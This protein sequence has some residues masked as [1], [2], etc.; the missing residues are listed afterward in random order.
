MLA[1]FVFHNKTRH[2][3]MNLFTFSKYFKH[4]D[5]YTYEKGE[6]IGIR[7]GSEGITFAIAGYKH[8]ID[9]LN[10]VQKIETIEAVIG[11]EIDERAY[12]GWQGITI[13]MCN[14]L[15]RAVTGIDIAFTWS[16]RHMY[17]KLLK[18]DRQS[19]YEIFYHWRRNN[20]L[21]RRG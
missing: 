16:P 14:E 10:E 11:A 20:G 6:W 12:F 8:G 5:I 2:K 7:M 18:Y 4:V 1:L 15:A 17:N 21:L 3:I 9:I 13:P 19:N